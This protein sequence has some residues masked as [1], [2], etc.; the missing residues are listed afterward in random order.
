MLILGPDGGGAARGADLCR[1][2]VICVLE[3]P[4]DLGPGHLLV[5]VE[6]FEAAVLAQ[7]DLVG[8]GGKG[9]AGEDLHHVRSVLD[10][11]G[12]FI[13]A[14]IRAFAGCGAPRGPR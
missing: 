7:V 6:P 14:D 4:P 1:S 9:N 10:I 8:G 5:L 2:E 13:P 11:E 12:R 3:E